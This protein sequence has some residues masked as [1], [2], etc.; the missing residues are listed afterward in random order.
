VALGEQLGSVGSFGFST[1]PHLHFEVRDGEGA[2]VDPYAGACGADTSGWTHQAK[3]VDPALL[4]IATHAKAPPT[5]TNCGDPDPG[6]AN[7]VQRSATVYAAAYLRD[8]L[9]STTAIIAILRPD[10]SVAASYTSGAPPSGFWEAAYLYTSYRLP[11]DAPLGEWRVRVSFV[12]RTSYHAFVVGTV[13][14]TATI[15]AALSA[16]VRTVSVGKEESFTVEVRNRSANRALGCRLSL[17]RPI[18]ADVAFRQLDATGTPTG[19]DNVPFAIPAKS[20]VKARLT[21]TP[22]AGFKASRA[23]FPLVAK[24]MN[25]ATAAFS[26]EK[27]MLTLTGGPSGSPAL[28]Q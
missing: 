7:R 1:G 26:R 4:R 2:V 9:A 10:G 3:P 18:N 27:T 12:G 23:E 16:P 13:P 24:C 11:A 20:T 25:S 19:L 5:I 17:W 28:S 8:Q 14:K 6:Y 22:R 21:V 15:T